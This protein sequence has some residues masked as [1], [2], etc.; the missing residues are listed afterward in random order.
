MTNFRIGFFFIFFLLFSVFLPGQSSTDFY[1]LVDKAVKKIYQNPDEGINYSQSLILNDKNYEHQLMLQHII[2]Q[3][4]AMK[5]DYLQ[6]VK[7]SLEKI[8]ADN[9]TISP[10]SQIFM[11]YSLGEQ[12]QNVG[13][14]RQSQRII[15]ETLLSTIEKKSEDPK[16]NITVSK[17]Y[18]LQAINF[19]IL[20]NYSSAEQN[21]QE[22]SRLLTHQ[23]HE[24]RIIGIENHIFQALYLLNQNKSAEAES[25]L[26]NTILTIEKNPDYKFLYAFAY[27]SLSRVYFARN[28]YNRAISCLQK[29]LSKIE[30][31]GYLPMQ[32]KIYENIA[33]NY[34]AL[35][36]MEDYQKFHHLNTQLKTQ[37]DTNKKD[38]I[39][40]IVKLVENYETK[41]LDFHTAVE[42][43]KFSALFIILGLMVLGLA[44]HFITEI[45]REKRLKKQLDFFKKLTDSNQISETD[46]NEKEI[47]EKDFTA[48]DEKETRK[49]VAISKEK[50]IEILQ[51]LD[52]MERSDRFLNKNMSLA[53]L[54]AQ[55]D[56]NTK[57][58]S[59]VINSYKGKNFNMYINELRIN[60]VAYLLKTQPAYLNYKVS[61]LAEISGF[62][63]HSSFTTVF[64]AI[65]GMSPNTFIQQ[66]N[67]K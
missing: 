66:I 49:T 17:L 41:N 63:S 39:R 48:D 43:K 19:G 2:A 14:Y 46:I 23:N 62:S 29:G 59:E 3:A 32:S 26:E 24:N 57:Y 16:V 11:D 21:I 56:T 58:L 36:N 8:D 44:I 51:K 55:L 4:Y 22:S 5:G 15:K 25:L 27:E 9:A 47:S 37:I 45:Y 10:F 60:H 65:T 12:Y 61:Y 52:E 28:D 54:A 18:Q 67:Q 31:L 34:F 33:K 50:E 6:S 42:K 40:Y 35:K 30:N 7:V 13:L 64:K 20:R 38:G 1:L 53:T